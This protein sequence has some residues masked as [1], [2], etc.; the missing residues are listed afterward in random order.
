MQVLEG[1]KAQNLRCQLELHSTITAGTTVCLFHFLKHLAEL[2]ESL[3]AW[4]AD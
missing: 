4:Q 3:V 2:V 1:E